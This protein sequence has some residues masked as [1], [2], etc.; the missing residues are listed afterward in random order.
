[1]VYT[2]LEQWLLRTAGC[3]SEKDNIFQLVLEEGSVRG[4]LH[5]A[6]KPVGKFNEDDM[7]FRVVPRIYEAVLTRTWAENMDTWPMGMTRG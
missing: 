6:R 5:I 4:L 1:M 7:S 2:L 3:L